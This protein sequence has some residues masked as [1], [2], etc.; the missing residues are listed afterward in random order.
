MPD[1]FGGAGWSAREFMEVIEVNLG[2]GWFRRLGGKLWLSRPNIFRRCQQRRWAE[3]YSDGPDVVVAGAV[4]PP[5]PVERDSMAAIKVKGRWGFGSG[6]ICADI[7]GV[8]I[9]VEDEK[10][11]L[12]R[13]AWMPPEQV[14]I[15]QTWNTMGMLGTGSHDLVVEDVVVPEG[16]TP[17]FEARRR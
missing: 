11:G 1:Q 3:I 5:Q 9:K 17:L 14:R 6:S 2:S 13:M 4:F 10:G 12:P 15:D 16:T 7:I 8:G